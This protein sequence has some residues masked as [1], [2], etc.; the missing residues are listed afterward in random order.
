MVRKVEA[1][2]DANGT[3]ARTATNAPKATRATSASRELVYTHDLPCLVC[4]V[5]QS[6]LAKAEQNPYGAKRLGTHYRIVEWALANAPDVRKLYDRL[7]EHA[8]A[9]PRRDPRTGRADDA[10]EWFARHEDIPWVLCDVHHQRATG[11]VP[12]ISSRF[13][14]SKT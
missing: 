13:D 11:G 14:G 7:V 6:T 4:G 3:G 12:E 9:R 1:G 8:R 10:R 5:R 2:R